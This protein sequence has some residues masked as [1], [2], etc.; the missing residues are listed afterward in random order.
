EQRERLHERSVWDLN[1]LRKLVVQEWDAHPAQLT[2]YAAYKVRVA[3]EK[4]K[5]TCATSRPRETRWTAPKKGVST[6][7]IRFTMHRNA[8]T[9]ARV[10]DPRASNLWWSP[11]KKR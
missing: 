9:M 1:S 11:I 8:L 4:K 2:T 5:N 3:V 10:A 7:L 6:Y